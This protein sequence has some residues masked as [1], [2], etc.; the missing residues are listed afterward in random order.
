M[1]YWYLL[2]RQPV[3]FF[4]HPTGLSANTGTTMMSDNVSADNA[5]NFFRNFIVF[6]FLL[7]F[8]VLIAILSLYDHYTRC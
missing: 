8:Y 5:I 6:F 1:V 7:L 2:Y 3:S 4:C